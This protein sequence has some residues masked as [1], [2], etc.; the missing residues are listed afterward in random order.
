[1]ALELTQ[2]SCCFSHVKVKRD[3]KSRCR[4]TLKKAKQTSTTLK[5]VEFGS[6]ETRIVFG[7]GT[8]RKCGQYHMIYSLYVLYKVVPMPISLFLLDS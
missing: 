4:G 7:L 5:C 2:Q 1:M 8:V 6:I 3:W